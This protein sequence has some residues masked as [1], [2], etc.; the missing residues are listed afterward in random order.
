MLFKVKKQS[1]VYQNILFFLLYL[2]IICLSSCDVFDTRLKIVN[3]TDSPVYFT[4][5]AD[6]AYRNLSNELMELDSLFPGPNVNIYRE[7]S[8]CMENATDTVTIFQSGN[9]DSVIQ[10]S[11][12]KSVWVFMISNSLSQQATRNEYK[13]RRIYTTRKAYSLEY[14]K[15]HNWL[16]VITEDDLNND[17]TSNY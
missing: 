7:L 12:N 17:N 6:S 5:C 11:M 13:T 3:V 8:I 9:W 15:K 10:K 16:I 1:K 2:I 14:L 4:V